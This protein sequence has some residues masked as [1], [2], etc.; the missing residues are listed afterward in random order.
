M[1]S[2]NA[3]VRLVL[4]A[5]PVFASGEL[6]P[7]KRGD[8]EVLKDSYVVILKDGYNLASVTD[9]MSEMNVTH[10]WTIVNGFTATLTQDDLNQLRAQPGVSSISENAAARSAA[11]Q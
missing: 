8:G 5:L 3:L 7:V 11:K 10:Q 1:R 2:T 6:L 9:S 4:L